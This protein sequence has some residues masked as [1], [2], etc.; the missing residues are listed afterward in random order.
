MARL[1]LAIDLAVAIAIEPGKT[2]LGDIC[3]EFLMCCDEFFECHAFV[4]IRVRLLDHAS[5][6][7]T[8][9]FLEF[10]AID[11]A[12]VILIETSERTLALFLR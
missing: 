6:W 2:R 9:A 3:G 11:E 1:V 7:T 4:A 5:D 12:I 8:M 10:M